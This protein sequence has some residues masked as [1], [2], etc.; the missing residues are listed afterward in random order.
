MVVKVVVRAAVRAVVRKVARGV[1]RMVVKV[2][3]RA[4]VGVE[5]RAHLRPACLRSPPAHLWWGLWGR[6]GG[7]VWGCVH[8]SPPGGV[9]PGWRCGWRGSRRG[10]MYVRGGGFSCSM[11][12]GGGLGPGEGSG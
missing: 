5:V 3:V 8:S 1:A 9:I 4:V 10:D 7:A 6:A 11:G 2:V 12:R